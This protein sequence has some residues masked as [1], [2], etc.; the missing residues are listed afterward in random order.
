V[1]ACLLKMKVPTEMLGAG[2]QPL[3]I[4][5]RLKALLLGLLLAV[6]LLLRHS[7]LVADM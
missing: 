1:K 7:F 6:L 3:R 2:H 4:T 5:N